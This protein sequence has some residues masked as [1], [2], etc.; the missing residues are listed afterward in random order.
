MEEVRMD[1]IGQTRL[2]MSKDATVNVYA[3]IYMKSQEDV[4]DLYFVMFNILSDPLRLSLCI[5][6]EFYDYLIQNHNYSV[7]QLDHMLKTNPEQY[8]A[9]VQS[10]YADMVNTSAV[11]KV[12]IS[13]DSQASADSAR[14]IVTSL[15][16]K[17]EFKQIS[18]YHIPGREPFVREQMVDTNPLKGEL[19]V[20][21]D[22]IK[23]WE[24]FDLDT[25]MKDL[26]Q[27]V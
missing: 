24:N 10:H 15:L 1:K 20:M 14:A 13:L 3:D 27:K 21:L 19:T 25:Y 16:S 8:L 5:V 23:K 2:T 11:E 22:I 9:L 17:G 7:G 26:S 6:S 12:K 4:D 18:T